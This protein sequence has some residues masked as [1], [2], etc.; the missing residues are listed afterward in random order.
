MFFVSLRRVSCEVRK[1]P[2]FVMPF[3]A[4][5]LLKTTLSDVQ[6]DNLILVVATKLYYQIDN[7]YGRVQRMF[8]PENLQSSKRQEFIWPGEH[9]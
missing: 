7:I 8:K 2:A 6:Y 3:F 9:F 5:Q 1:E 4:T